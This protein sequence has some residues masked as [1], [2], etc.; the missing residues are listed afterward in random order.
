MARTILLHT[1]LRHSSIW[2]RSEPFEP[3]SAWVD[4]LMRA[5]QE[6][7]ELEEIKLEPGQVLTTEVALG[8]SWNWSRTRVRKFLTL[9]TDEKMITTKKTSKYSLIS[10]T[11]WAFHQNILPKKNI[12]LPKGQVQE[13]FNYWALTLKHPKSKLTPDKRKK[14]AS[15]LKERYTVEEL[16]KTID[17]CKASE[18]HQG[19]NDDR[20]VYDTIDLL[21]RNGGKVEFFWGYL[22]KS[23]TSGEVRI[24]RLQESTDKILDDRKN[25]QGDEKGLE[26][27]R[28]LKETVRA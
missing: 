24:R 1:K 7:Q 4:L 13:V 3:R 12:T 8:H 11:K 26:K 20:K 19:K 28:K 6:K 15:R 21:F 27:L 23:L 9:L 10:I 18:Y 16:K 2:N 17:G 22:K 14:I 25:W 5:Q